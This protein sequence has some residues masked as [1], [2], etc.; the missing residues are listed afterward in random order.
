VKSLGPSLPKQHH[1]F[2][3]LIRGLFGIAQQCYNQMIP[4][5]RNSRFGW[6]YLVMVMVEPSALLKRRNQVSVLSHLAFRGPRLLQVQY[7]LAVGRVNPVQ[8]WNPLA[9]QRRFQCQF[10]SRANQFQDNPSG[11][12]IKT[13]RPLF[14]LRPCREYFSAD[15]LDQSDKIKVEERGGEDPSGRSLFEVRPCQVDLSADDLD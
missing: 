15:D 3:I 8:V 9:E 1:Y 10:R 11:G 7:P 5:T 2:G 6:C 4:F 13:R 12:S 14:E